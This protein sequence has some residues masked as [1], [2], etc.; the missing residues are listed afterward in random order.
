MRITY[1]M[2]NKFRKIFRRKTTHC[3]LVNRDAQLRS[4]D[5][6]QSHTADSYMTP[7]DQLEPD[8]DVIRQPNTAAVDT[9]YLEPHDSLYV[10]PDN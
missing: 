5:N 3:L 7:T 8:Y 2:L 9:E 4:S 6:S 1:V 10:T